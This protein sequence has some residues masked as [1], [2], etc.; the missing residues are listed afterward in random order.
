[1]AQNL[2]RII[3][4]LREIRNTNNTNDATFDRLLNSLSNKVDNIDKNTISVELIKSY[5][6]DLTK[7]VDNKYTTTIEK[8]T[9]IEQALKAIFN[10]KDDN[11]TINDLR[12]LFEAFSQ[13]LSNF[14]VEIKQQ[15]AIISG[16]ESRIAEM[17]NN[18]SDKEEILRTIT[19]LRND[20]ENLNHA[21]K[22][23]IDHISSELK[24]IISNLAKIDQ[25]T[26][27]EDIK[28]DINDMYKA[29]GD[30][31][32]FLKTIDKHES[33]LE[34]LLKSTAT[35]DSLKLTQVAVDTIMSKAD[36][37][38][39]QLEDLYDE[40]LTKE[41]FKDITKKAEELNKST[42]EVKQALAL[43][44]KDIDSLPDT[45][46]LKEALQH[47]YNEIK[48]IGESVIET[49]VKGDVREL[50]NKIS[51]FLN[52]LRTIKNIIIDL[53]E[54]ISS[55]LLST[56]ENI[57][58]EQESFDIKNH[59]SNMI[60]KLPQKEDVDKILENEELS[61]KAIEKLSQK[62]DNL[63]DMLDNLPTH[64]DMETLNSNQL[65][66][67]ENLQGVAN[68]GD[69]EALTSKADDIEKMI[70]K[71]NFDNE[72]EH[73]Y[74]KSSSIEKWLID[75]NVKENTE[76]ILRNLD[77]KAEQKE[78][79]EV[80][81]TAERIVN[82]IE[83]LSKNVDAKKVNRTVA[84]VYQLIEDL[85]NDF[86]NT[87]EM[88]NDTVIVN[89]SELQK[90]IEGVVT[91]EEF[92][93]FVEDLKSFV[94]KTGETMNNNNINFDAIREYQESIITKIDDINTSAIEEAIS[95]QVSGLDDKLVSIS[96]YLT[97]TNRTDTNEVKKAI[98]EI[99]EILANKKS[100]IGE[101]DN[102]RKET[103]TSL[104]N[105]L[106]EIKVVLDTSDKETDGSIKNQINDLEAKFG[107][108]QAA[109]EKSLTEIISKLEEYKD[110][111]ALQQAKNLD[112]RGSINELAELNERVKELGASFANL[113][114]K[115]FPSANIS[116][117]VP[118]KLED[119]SNNL[120]ELSEQIESGMQAGFAYTSQL[121]EEK[122]D[123]LADFIKELRHES[124]K[125]IELYERLTVTDNKLI[126]I[127]QSLEWLNSD[128]I[129]NN[130]NQAEMLLKEILSLKNIVEEVSKTSEG[131]E[132]TNFKQDL[133][134]FHEAIKANLEDVTKYSK[135]TYDTLENNY[136]QISSDLTTSENNL[137]DFILGDIDSVLLKIDNLKDEVQV[138]TGKLYVPNAQQMKEFKS[139]VEDINSFKES[140]T[141]FITKTAEDVKQTI[142]E[143]LKTQHEDLKSLLKVAVNTE[144]ILTA[145][146]SLKECFKD[147][148]Q[149]FEENEDAIF[150]NFDNN[151]KNVDFDYEKQAKLVDELKVDF[152][153]FSEL[154]TCLTGENS[155]VYE[156]LLQIKDKMNSISVV[157][158]DVAIPELLNNI[159]N[160][161][162]TEFTSN[163]DINSD[164]EKTLVGDDNF[165]FIKAFNLLQG[166]IE[167]LKQNVYKI[168]PNAKV[169][170]EKELDKLSEIINPA[171]WLEDIKTYMSSES[172]IKSMLT[173]ISEKI[174]ILTSVDE[175]GIVDEV[176][177]A[178]ES[179]DLGKA[180]IE[181]NHLLN[182]INTKLDII[183][184]SDFS[185]DL[186]DIKYT[187]A[188]V[189]ERV[190]GVD[191]FITS[192]LED[193]NHKI[194]NIGHDDIEDFQAIKDLIIAQTDYIENFERNNKTEALRKCLKELTVEVN[195]LN[196]T[197]STKSIQK[198]IKEMKTSIMDAVVSIFN[199]VSFVEESEDI[200]DFVEEKTDEIN[201]NLV[202]VTKQLKQITN[203][204]EEPDYTYSMQ[205][206]ESDLAKMRLALNELQTNEQENHTTRLTSIIDNLAEIGSN[207]ENLQNSLTQEEIFGMKSKFE[208]INEDINELIIRSSE[209][210]E[211][212]ADKLTT[213]VDKVTKLLEKSND[214][215]KVMRQALIYMGEWIDSASAS[216]NKISSNSDEI[217][218]VK[219][220][221]EA[222][223]Q[224]VPNQTELLNSLG[225]KFDEQQE[226]LAFFEKQITKISGLQD[227]FEEQQERI[228]RLEMS[229]E[230][231]LSAVED[232]DD[233]KINRKIDKIDKQIAKLSS[234]IEK[235]ASY[236]D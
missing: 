119:I 114:T 126:D 222:L 108:Y 23:I 212:I 153:K 76:A 68:K 79:L 27:N 196:E 128:I 87:A 122:V 102:I 43:I 20:F 231:I 179:L 7:S 53:N 178:I 22:D 191:T 230:K 38:A 189:D 154:I 181:N 25:T 125:D 14:S 51:D 100:N 33:N 89:L 207:V 110:E 228:D 159:E 156:I 186:D 225:E 16:I 72:F 194:D 204:N 133:E 35:A 109:S 17:S 215:D 205:D 214:S 124:T 54:I 164:N 197:G 193:L 134:N 11:I 141:A 139:F 148:I 155:E 71:L 44:T 217:I 171:S 233:S 216:M 8:F 28:N 57:S 9:D 19:L 111:L 131:I 220:A 70:D 210:Y 201:K 15:K 82:N 39:R 73:I 6:T 206:I 63:A 101:F 211:V 94:D 151:D 52:E 95:R 45:K 1:M 167:K 200:K 98:S 120:S 130:N 158:P 144:E 208:K 18:K 229:L 180:D 5:L 198:T 93:N 169:T 85:K 226:R 199:Q 30:I 49:Q 209:S 97:T 117:I 13:N 116:E 90:S 84:E 174:D 107:N 213:K 143:Q 32:S 185:D 135:S 138:A 219:M 42:D 2:E 112:Y 146:D 184:Q 218:D 127:K 59:V 36:R 65:S 55:K 170:D 105:Y 234:N 142:S 103:I 58:F 48:E 26:I 12:D 41:H 227:K 10:S 203:A 168:I 37:I 104:E 34:Q 81:K 183:A 235:L 115:G 232:I 172:E 4:L 137:R 187:L 24:T 152:D 166:D 62:T 118:S 163:I 75:S 165:D 173:K 77:E 150:D 40:S 69:I 149:E 99:K 96:E 123:T 182:V 91:G 46:L 190:D 157:R 224:N 132:N 202:E 147:K 3:D 66:L 50:S 188:N 106:R 136:K 60:A 176:K 74:D 113:S 192:M 31:I 86:M 221:I 61:I 195:N 145:I 177:E 78:V 21:Y 223:K 161:D 67:V 88:H 47:L 160:P 80:L 175:Y 29:T 121:V 140:Q 83:E 64:S 162:N 129:N 236:V 92:E 56:V